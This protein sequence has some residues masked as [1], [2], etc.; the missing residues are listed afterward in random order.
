M[1]FSLCV[2]AFFFFFLVGREG[3]GGG[4]DGKDVITIAL[5]LPVCML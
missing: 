5:R 2:C 4:G 3:G 1:Y